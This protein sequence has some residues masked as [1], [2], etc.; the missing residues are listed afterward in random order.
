MKK[1]A[2]LNSTYKTVAGSLFRFLILGI[3]VAFLA[4][5]LNI[6][7][8]SG[9]KIHQY[10]GTYH[11]TE[12]SWVFSQGDTVL[13]SQ[14]QTP[15]FRH[16]KTGEIYSISTELTYDG[17]VDPHPY[18]FYFVDHM[19]TRALIDNQ[20]LFSYMPEDVERTD[21]GR[22][23]GNVYVSFELPRDCQGRL[24][25]IEF[26]PALSESIDFQLP[27]PNFGNYSTT[28]VTTFWQDLPHNIVAVLCAF[29]G[30]ASILFSTLALTGSKYREGLFIGIFAMLCSLYNITESDLD[31]YAI[32]N[33]YFTYILDYTTF[34]LMPIFLMAFLRERLAKKQK[35]LAFFMIIVGIVMY[36]TMVILHFTGLVDMR[37]YLPLLH[38]VYF[39]DLGILFLLLVTMK[40]DREK[41]RLSVQILPILVGMVIDAAVYYLHWSLGSSDST[42]TFIGII[43]F[44]M[45]ELYHVWKY[46]IDVYMESVRSESYKK[47]AYFDSLTGI[48][49]RRAFELEKETIAS[50]RKPFKSMIVASADLNDLKPTNDNLGHAAGDFL[51]R[52]AANVLTELSQGYGNAFRVGG[53]E[54]SVLLYDMEEEELQQRIQAMHRQIEEINGKSEAKLSLALGYEPCRREDL[55]AAIESADKKMYMEKGR[56]KAMKSMEASQIR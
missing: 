52:S 22:S 11:Y 32:S 28:V 14:L 20:V 8:W 21:Q 34:S 19:Y 15:A 3:F 56:L 30:L 53:D 44:L 42:F 43:F 7:L 48:G 1:L 38:V 2:Y 54:F 5:L 37:E 39:A 31:F 49:N 10:E 40:K 27:N 6:G 24:L 41:T 9:H 51:I 47:M 55:E 4:A 26:Q 35:P 12:S 45:T 17:T 23:P 18:C 46:S 50:A 25:T 29:L 33:P 36:V 13:E 16:M